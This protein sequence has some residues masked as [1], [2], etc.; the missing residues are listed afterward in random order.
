MSAR[1]SSLADGETVLISKTIV[2]KGGCTPMAEGGIIS[3]AGAGR[4]GHSEDT[5]KGGA[6]LN[7]PEPVN[8]LVRESPPRMGDLVKWGA[9]FDFTEN[10]ELAQRPFGGQRF[11]RTCYAG[12][13]TGH[14]MMMTLVEHLD[15]TGV[16]TLQEYT[17]ID[18]LKDG[19]AVIGAM[20]LDEKGDLVV[21][22]AD[23]Y[24]PCHGWGNQDL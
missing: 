6:Y 23:R 10:D 3:L 15:S 2:G 16:T 11:A 7:N 5:L 14:E 4:M 8:L 19:D 12:D 22:K 17:V 18:L 21:L 13:R 20:A 24:D 9:V 1:R